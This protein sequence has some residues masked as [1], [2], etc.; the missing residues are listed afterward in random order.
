MKCFYLT[1]CFI[2]AIVGLCEAQ[3]EPVTIGY[4]W[5]KHS[6]DY[7]LSSGLGIY[8]DCSSKDFWKA[9]SCAGVGANYTYTPAK[10]IRMRAG[11]SEQFYSSSR[12]V[13]HPYPYVMDMKLKLSTISTRLIA[14][15][16][17]V[18]PK[19][20]EYQTTFVGLGLYGDVIHYAKAS[21]WPN[22]ISHTG[23]ETMNLKDSFSFI[24]PGIMFNVGIQGSL[25]RLDL[26]YMV[27]ITRFDIPG[28]PIGKQRRAFIGLNFAFQ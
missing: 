1:I 24:T 13:E 23:L 27:D 28:V 10:H 14:G 2:I 25:G 15:S 22:Y 5:D 6:I 16:E 3:E 8:R 11:I 7:E 21:A 9:G 12:M 26:R 19:T 4:T 18:F 20:Q 17:W